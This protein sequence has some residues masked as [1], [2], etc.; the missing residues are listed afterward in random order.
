VEFR[1]LRAF[2]A[3]ADSRSFSKAARLLRMAQPPLSRHIRQLENELGVKVFVRTTS[4][5]HLTCEGAIL[6]EKARDLLAHAGAFLELAARMKNGTMSLLKIGIAPGLGE[7]VNRIR[8]HML[9]RQPEISI[10]GLDVVSGR[11]YDALRQG[12]IDVGVLRHVD[13]RAAVES[14]PL[15]EERFV[16]IL[17]DRHP[18]SRRSLHLKQ[19]AD[20]PLLLHERAWAPLA[21]DKI[22]AL[23]AAA[24]VGPGIVTLHAE[25][26]DQASML[27]VASG[28]GVC[29]AL[30]G[31]LSRS[32]VTVS[33]VSVVPLDEPDAVLQV[34]VAWRRGQTSKGLQNFVA[35]AHALF[36]LNS[37]VDPDAHARRP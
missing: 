18:L 6:L 16:V 26:G 2:A 31:A 8:L 10:E 21:H 9:E 24:G 29:L 20:V 12:S 27:A 4:G 25:P 23:Y 13:D 36:P 33:G 37:A 17:S 1:H 30:R 5:V 15:F 3:V 32:Y 11:Q 35:A 28:D 22:L 34:R 14:E 19:L 7:A